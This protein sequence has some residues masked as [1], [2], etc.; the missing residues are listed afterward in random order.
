[1]DRAQR[2]VPSCLLCRQSQGDLG[3]GHWLLGII[4]KALQ[5]TAMADDVLRATA[6]LGGQGHPAGAGDTRLEEYLGSAVHSSD[7]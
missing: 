2:F 1:M 4:P 7:R 3:V 5:V 6:Y